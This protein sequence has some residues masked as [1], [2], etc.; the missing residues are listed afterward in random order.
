MLDRH[1]LSDHV[2]FKL[3]V[4]LI[5]SLLELLSAFTIIKSSLT[6]PLPGLE[7]AT[8]TSGTQLGLVGACITES[9]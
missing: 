7:A 1:R 4:L 2:G 6:A 8:P 3:L 5:L 9:A